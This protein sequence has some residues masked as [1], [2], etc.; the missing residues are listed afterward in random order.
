MVKIVLEISNEADLRILLPL[1]KRLSIPHRIA[2]DPSSVLTE[3]ERE[4]HFAII[5][6][7]VPASDM[8]AHLKGL[9]EARKDRPKPSQE[10]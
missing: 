2:D 3:A 6:E 8:E 1:L 4:A 7:G 10:G 9:E 5:D